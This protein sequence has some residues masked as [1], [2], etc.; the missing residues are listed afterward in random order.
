ME[1]RIQ[2][3]N[4]A[5]EKLWRRVLGDQDTKIIKKR[6]K[7]ELKAN[8]KAYNIRTSGWMEAILERLG[9][10]RMVQCG[11]ADFEAAHRD[12]IK[13]RRAGRKAQQQQE[14]A[15]TLPTGLQ[16]PVCGLVTGARVGLFGNRW[17]YEL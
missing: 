16:C 15:P 1:H 14:E 3:I 2:A 10:K 17:K 6:H 5:F 8:L 9:W 13:N 7:D 12:R 11:C 4:T